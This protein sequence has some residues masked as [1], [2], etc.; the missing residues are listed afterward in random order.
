MGRQSPIAIAAVKIGSTSVSVLAASHL[1]API[2]EASY[3]LGLLTVAD[4]VQA[5]APTLAAIRQ[6]LR[7]HGVGPVLVATG[8]VGRRRA[9]LIPYLTQQGWSPWVLTGHE[10][11]RAVWWGVQANQPDAV[12]VVDVGGGSTEVVGPDGAWSL[13]FG[14]ATPLRAVQV[15]LSL[16]GGRELVAVG[17]TARSLA[18]RE[19]SPLLT[20]DALRA[21]LAARD[22]PEL[23]SGQLGISPLRAGLL[24]GGARALLA[25]LEALGLP[26]A[27]VSPRDLRHG[28]WL[29]AAMG[30]GGEGWRA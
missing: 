30:R 6:G 5:L 11:A 3:D 29:A 22:A 19:G 27:R 2:W 17:G 20:A 1:N 4:P 18:R 8:E 12:T 14:A 25:V 10:E 13:P 26:H 21:F 28:L 16:A 23:L 9:D 24:A 7:A 15:P